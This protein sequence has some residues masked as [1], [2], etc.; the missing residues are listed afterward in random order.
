MEENDRKKGAH[1]NVR[2]KS[3]CPSSNVGR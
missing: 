2:A 1:V 3:Y